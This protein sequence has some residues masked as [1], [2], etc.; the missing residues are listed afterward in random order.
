MGEPKGLAEAVEQLT[1]F[2]AGS[3][4][5]AIVP[6]QEIVQKIELSPTDINVEGEG[7]WFAS[8]HLEVDA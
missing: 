3:N 5:G 7:L 4:S 8:G 2:L 1:Q 6:R